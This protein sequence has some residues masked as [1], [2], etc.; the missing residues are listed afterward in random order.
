MI[1]I[2]DKQERTRF[3]KFLVVGSI[4]FVVDFSV[5]N[6]FRSGVGLSPELSSVISFVAAVI[7][8]FIFNRYWTYPDS[9]SKPLLGQLIQFALVNVIGLGIRTLIFSIINSPLANMF[10]DIL[11]D[12]YIS[13]NIIGENIALAIVVIIVLFWNFFVNRYWTY[14]DID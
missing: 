11:P 14:N 9:R 3:F 8:N 5:F 10:D 13:G 2:K 6:L 4:G 1:L 12:F 7:S